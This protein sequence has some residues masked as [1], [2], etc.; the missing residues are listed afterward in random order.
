MSDGRTTKLGLLFRSGVLDELTPEDRETLAALPVTHVLDYRDE[1]EARQ[2]PDLLW[3]N[4]QYECVPANPDR[5]ETGASLAQL[6]SGAVDESRAFVFMKELYRRLPFNNPAYQRLLTWLR[7]QEALRLV[8][9][10]AIGKDR[11]GVGS[12]IVLLALG[13]ERQTVVEDYMVT[14]TSLAS[15]RERWMATLDRHRMGAKYDAVACVFSAREAFIEAALEAIELRYG[16]ITCYLQEEFGL[17]SVGR[18]VLQARYL[19]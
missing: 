3:R 14:E 16:G 10:C 9:H 13:A 18:A 1:E 12:A 7:T 8:Q 6:L 15:Y 19:E 5:W 2:K 4:V 11:T 17:D